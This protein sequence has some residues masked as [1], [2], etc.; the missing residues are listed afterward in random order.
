MENKMYTVEGSGVFPTDMLRYDFSNFLDDDEE[1]KSHQHGRRKIIL[2]SLT[3]REPSNARWKSF[4][5][6]IV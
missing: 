3:K 1:T 5:W 4:N 2:I 6:R